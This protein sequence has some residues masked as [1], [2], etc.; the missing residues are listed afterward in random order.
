MTLHTFWTLLCIFDV[1][2]LVVLAL[3][4]NSTPVSQRGH[5]RLSRKALSDSCPRRRGE[6]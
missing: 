5:S 6:F 2:I 3:A 4:L 1:L